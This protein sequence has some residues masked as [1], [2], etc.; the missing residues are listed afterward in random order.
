MKITKIFITIVVLLSATVGGY[1]RDYPEFDALY[2]KMSASSVKMEYSYDFRQSTKT[3]IT[4]KAVITVQ[5]SSYV[6]NGNGL[7]VFCDG[8]T[9]WTVDVSAKEVVIDALIPGNVDIS[10]P[11]RLFG[12]LKDCFSITESIVSSAG[13]TYVLVPVKPCGINAC[14][15]RISGGK[16]SGASFDIDGGELTVE[17]ESMSFG[18]KL[19]ADKFCFDV[20]DLPADYIITD[21][22]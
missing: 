9:V 6:M 19:S 7:E 13:V 17:V 18:E 22:R 1:S 20:T 8:K 15:V 10:N 16:L 4:G 14:M 12:M 11:A 2:D 3:K 5:D 21:L